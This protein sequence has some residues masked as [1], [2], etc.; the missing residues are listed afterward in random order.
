M[1]ELR[2][3]DMTTVDIDAALQRG[4]DTV[5]VVATA[6]D[7]HSAHLPMATDYY[8]GEELARRVAAELNGRAL[9][10]PI[11]PCGPNEEMMGFAGTVS[12]RPDT[13][14]AVLHD[15]CA[16]YARHGFRNAVLLTSHEGDFA[17]LTRAREVCAYLPMRIVAFDDL[18]ALV[19]T[20][21][22]TARAHGVDVLAAGAHAGEFETSLMLA[23]FPE[24]VR[25]DALQAG[26][27]I[28]LTQQPLFFRQDLRRVTPTG[29]IGDARAATAA[30]GERY[31]AALTA[32][33][34]DF[35]RGEGITPL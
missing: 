28:D 8:W 31:W 35:L 22:H 34:L 16:S 29:I 26:L 7:Q 12:L 3:Q 2:M 33:I 25:V 6:Q 13:L 5:I 30:Q 15:M 11:I 19:S 21:Q 17:P 27:M 23:A 18:G 4:A 14:V 1:S 24:K 10:A 9:I 32:M 20:V